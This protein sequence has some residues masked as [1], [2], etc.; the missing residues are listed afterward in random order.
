METPPPNV[1]GWI[2]VIGG[3]TEHRGEATG[4]NQLWRK[5]RA[6]SGPE[7]CVY[8]CHWNED[9]SQLAAFIAENSER[10]RGVPYIHVAGY[11]WGAGHGAIQLAKRLKKRGLCVGQMTLCDPVY[12]SKLTVTRWVAMT[13][14]ALT[15]T[16]PDNVRCV[17][18]FAQ[19][20]DRPQAFPVKHLGDVVTPEILDAT[21][22]DIDE[23]E[24]YHTCVLGC[25]RGLAHQLGLPPRTIDR[26]N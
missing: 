11:S 23:H 3:F 19:E 12:R 20:N 26:P 24:V 6:L 10:E 15:I 25:A 8:F 7:L 21:H 9:F 14:W 4:T 22:T 17:T 1:Q 13:A 16:V 5:L 18:V 2:I